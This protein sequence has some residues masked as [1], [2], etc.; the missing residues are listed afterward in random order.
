M[1]SVLWVK[2]HGVFFN[3]HDARFAHHI[4]DT[5]VFTYHVLQKTVD[6]PSLQACP[7]NDDILCP[8]DYQ[9][10]I[11]IDLKPYPA[12]GYSTVIINSLGLRAPPR[13]FFS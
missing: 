9:S 7:V 3:H 12:F 13:Y 4:V 10:G 5:T 8:S 1:W 6:I 11:P 2:T